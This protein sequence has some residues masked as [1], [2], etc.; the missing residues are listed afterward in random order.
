MPIQVEVPGQGLVEF[1]DGM[2]DDQIA[3]AIKQNM[4]A[5][6][7]PQKP[8]KVGIGE[9]FFQGAVTDPFSAM[10]QIVNEALP[11]S[12]KDKV[13]VEGNQIL[14]GL[15]RKDDIPEAGL[16]AQI[17]AREKDY[18]Q[19][20]GGNPGF[21]WGRLGGN[22][23]ASIPLSISP[24]LEIQGGKK[25]FDLAN[26]L[27]SAAQGGIA[28]AMQ[29]V[30]QGNFSDEKLSQ[31]S[32]GAGFGAAAQ[33]VSAAIGNVISP[34]VRPEVEALRKE[35][36]T[37]TAG[38]IL[39]GNWQRAEDK[40]MSLPIVGDMIKN[41]RDRSADQLNR[42]AYARVLKGSGIDAQSLP[43]GAE[44]L[45]AV[46]S[47]VSKQYDDLLPKLSFKAD[48]QFSTELQNLRSMAANLAPT[49][50]K[51]FDSIINEHLSKVSHNGNMT[52]E[53]YK[54]LESALRNDA[55]KFTSSSDAYQREL[56]DA[57]KEAG[58][59]FKSALERN[60]PQYAKELADV[61]RNYA[62]FSILRN[63]GSRAGAPEGGFSPA[64]LAA[65]VKASDRSVG[66]GATA[67]GKAMMQDLASAGRILESKVPNSG[68][69]DRAALAGVAGLGAGA[70]F[71]P[72]TLVGAG[73]GMLPYTKTGQ[74][75]TA[76]LL[77]KRPE[78]AKQL[79]DALR[80][81]A[82]VS[83]AVIAEQ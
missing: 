68:T 51:R 4:P 12:I 7:A 78:A 16:N 76:D 39:G 17:A 81:I 28:G 10:G 63:A 71:E 27:R 47:A 57:L 80:R 29:P 30:T 15:G 21:D 77:T 9:S 83:G 22:V 40:A 18:Q 75:I 48:P 64:Q 62:N 20:R 14:K 54:I 42:A 31:I 13:R 79:A 24:G 66:K 2:S 36:V 55:K 26:M 72:T 34:K 44:G 45:D 46:K 53:T 41:A 59:V 56:G 65:A 49:E 6:P 38:Q 69:V 74:K 5:A 35:G 82:P 8:N 19:R 73:V 43:V 25:A 61:N 60:N 32:T 67:T 3:A 70:F 50:A 33:P 11:Q 1:P 23:A 37:P 52:G 58:N